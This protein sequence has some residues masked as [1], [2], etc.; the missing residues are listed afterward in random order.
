MTPDA[1]F[2]ILNMLAVAAWILLIVLPRQRWVT[3]LVT[4]AVVPALFAA[5]YVAI[6]ATS[7]GSS[8]GGFSTLAGVA[9][10]FE[11]PWLLLAGWV[12]YLAFDLLVGSWEVRDARAHDIPH[13]LIVPCLVLTFLFG[14]VGWLLYMALRAARGQGVR[15]SVSTR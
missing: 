2:S 12:H 6:L 4:A 1:L 7:W 15:A 8:E 11:N 5:T 3:D 14:P 10:L 9:R 13:L